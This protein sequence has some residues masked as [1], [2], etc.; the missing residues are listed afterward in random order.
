MS[1][2]NKTQKKP[3]HRSTADRPATMRLPTGKSTS[4]A[5]GSRWR[6]HLQAVAAVTHHDFR[7]PLPFFGGNRR[8][9]SGSLWAATG[10]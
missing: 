1:Q 2:K 10:G 7:N 4:I 6:A 9:A 3:T 8:G 5:R